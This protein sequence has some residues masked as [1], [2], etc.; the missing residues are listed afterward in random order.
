M[1]FKNNK[2]EK[3]VE[4]P[5]TKQAAPSDIATVSGYVLEPTIFEY[6]HKQMETRREDEEFIQQISMQNMIKDGHKFYGLVIK[7]GRY[8]DSGNK[9]EYLKTV[10]DFALEHPEVKDDFAKYLRSLQL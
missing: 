9:L 2:V 6:L 4:K 7:N 5:G 8:Y 10:V 1:K 3:I